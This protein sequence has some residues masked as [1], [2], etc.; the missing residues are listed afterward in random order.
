MLNLPDSSLNGLHSVQLHKVG[1]MLRHSTSFQS[2]KV[3]HLPLQSVTHGLRQRSISLSREGRSHG[4]ITRR[5]WPGVTGVPLSTISF[6][7]VPPTSACNHIEFSHNQHM[8]LIMMRLI[9]CP[10]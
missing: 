7:T 2:P 8:L 3:A 4:L 10:V 6:V 1:R 5:A 9:E